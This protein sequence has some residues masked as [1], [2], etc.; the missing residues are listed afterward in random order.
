[1]DR[2]TDNCYTSLTIVHHS[3]PSLYI[4]LIFVIW[5][6]SIITENLLLLFLTA[7]SFTAFV[8]QVLRKD[9]KEA[10]TNHNITIDKTSFSAVGKYRQH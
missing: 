7:F 5:L 2:W 6:S 9:N 1:M 8:V 4:C 3:I 10:N